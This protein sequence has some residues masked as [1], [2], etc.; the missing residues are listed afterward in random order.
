MGG[1]FGCSKKSIKKLIPLID[2]VL[3]KMLSN[4]IVNNEQIALGYLY[5]NYSDL[6][7][8]FLNDPS[9]HRAYELVAELSN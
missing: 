3:K 2:D 6:F 8:E 1:M 5:K 9:K 4:S 7:A